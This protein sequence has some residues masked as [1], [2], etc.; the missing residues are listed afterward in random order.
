MY[1]ARK[2]TA[3][4]MPEY[5]TC[6]PATIS[7]SPSTTSNGWRLVS[8][9]PRPSR[10]RTGQQRQPVPRQ[11]VHAVAG[12]NAALLPRHDI[13]QVQAARGHQH[14]DQCEA[15]RDLIADHLGRGAQRAEERVLRVRRPAGEDHAVHPERGDR[16][17]VQ[18][19]GVDV[20]STAPAWNG[21]TAQAASA[22]MIVMI[23]AI[24]GRSSGWPRPAD[25][26]LKISLTASA[27]G[28]SRPSGPTR[29][30]PRRTCVQPIALRSQSVR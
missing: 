1:S 23:G 16:H 3:N 9:I 20:A 2:N 5:S 8:A 28:C 6:E 7:D 18:Q 19:T 4:A 24:T 30:G 27:I 11:D 17:H 29:F 14:D 15:H 22:G 10:R 12:E 26:S 25:H 21:I 13:A